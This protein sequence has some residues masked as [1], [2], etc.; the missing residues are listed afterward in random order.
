MYF[1][2][3]PYGLE[4]EPMIEEGNGFQRRV[5]ILKDGLPRC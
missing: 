2:D 5:S 4:E 3:P 1:T